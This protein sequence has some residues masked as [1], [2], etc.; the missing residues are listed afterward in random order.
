MASPRSRPR[1][2]P[3]WL[4]VPIVAMALALAALF[5]W[6]LQQRVAWLVH[7]PRLEGVVVDVVSRPGTSSGRAGTSPDTSRTKRTRAGSPP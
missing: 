6:I 5:G 7:A 4:A 2:A 3:V 1:P